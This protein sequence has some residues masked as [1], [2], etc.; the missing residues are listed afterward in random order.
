MKRT[1]GA[2]AAWPVPSQRQLL[3]VSC[4]A[5]WG[6]RA[7][8]AA[9]SRHRGTRAMHVVQTPCPRPTGSAPPAPE[10]NTLFLPAGAPSRRGGRGPS[11]FVSVPI[12]HA[13]KG[14][15][16][17]NSERC[18]GSCWQARGGREALFCPELL[19]EWKC[20][21]SELIFIK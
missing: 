12:N 14:S 5:G 8:G 1:P 18:F 19:Q 20:F 13:D 7:Q 6:G 15:L 17:L 3:D 21:F 2:P 10:G 4:A 16:L 11:L 9:P